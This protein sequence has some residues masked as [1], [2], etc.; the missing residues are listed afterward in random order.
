MKQQLGKKDK[1][2]RVLKTPFAKQFVQ[3]NS[4]TG[5]NPIFA[6]LHGGAAQ[7]KREEGAKSQQ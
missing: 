1:K 6:T 4:K 3:T 2:K 5:I 7:P